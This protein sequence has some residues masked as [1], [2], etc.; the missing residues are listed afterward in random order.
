L[1]TGRMAHRSK[2]AIVY[3]T[4]GYRMIELDAKPACGFRVWRATASWI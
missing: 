2:T 3:F 1:P 4:Q